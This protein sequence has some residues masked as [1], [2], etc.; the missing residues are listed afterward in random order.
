MANYL[1][2]LIA[3]ISEYSGVFVSRLIDLQ[4]HRDGIA[5]SDHYFVR[6]SNPFP[7]TVLKRLIASDPERQLYDS[8]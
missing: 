2:N 5:R 1:Y 3:T 8:A 4:F 7:R 6:G